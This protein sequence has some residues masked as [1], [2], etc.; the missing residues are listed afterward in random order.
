[1]STQVLVLEE[2]SL[3]SPFG[4]RLWDVARV[5]PAEGGLTI[6]AYPDLY[7]ELRTAAVE[8]HIGVYSFSGL[9]GL[10]RIEN[11]TG[12]AAFWSANTTSIPYTVEVYDPEQRYLPYRFS[13][14]LPVRGLFGLWESP[15]LSGLTPDPSWLPVFSDPARPIAGPAATISAQLQD[16]TLTKPAAWALLTVQAPGL[17]LV[18]GLADQR[19]VLA[20]SQPYPEPTDSGSG[21]PLNAPKL[22][23]QNWPIEVSVFYTAHQA[24]QAVADLEQIL[25]QS[26]AVAWRDTDHTAPADH[27]NL[28]FGQDLVLRS[29]DSNTG[30]EL[31][32]LLVT[33][34]A[35]PL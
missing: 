4:V 30:R 6:V 7:P 13:T 9:P 21:S 19:G 10:R 17:P 5:A 15:L 25:H 24:S 18:T 35:S 23:D 3:T 33:S 14:R 16:E 2:I 22:T 27:F 1:M 26:A 28:Q 11:S 31:P 32:V 29:I 20:I 12:D 8:N 34:T